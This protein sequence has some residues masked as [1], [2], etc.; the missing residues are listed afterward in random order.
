MEL[1]QDFKR[2]YGWTPEQRA[3]LLHKARQI[4]AVRTNPA[5]Y[6]SEDLDMPL[7]PEFTD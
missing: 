2:P 4:R 6:K 1:E 5:S 3:E 7:L